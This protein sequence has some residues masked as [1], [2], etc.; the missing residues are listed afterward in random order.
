MSC[1][2]LITGCSEGG[3][4]FTLCEEFASRGCKV[5]ATARRMEAMDK[6]GHANIVKLRLDVTDDANVTDVV[7]TI[8]DRE[9]KIDVLVNNA[10]IL[11]TGAIADVPMDKVIKTFDANVFAVLRLVKA[12]F[13]HMATRKSGAIVNIGSL[14][15]DIPTPWS[16]I[17]CATKASLRSISETLWMECSPFNISVTHVSA[18][19]VR[20]N[21]STTAIKSVSLPEG[22][23]YS[24]WFDSMV[25]RTDMSQIATSMP[26]EDFARKVVTAVLSRSPP[27]YMT[28][29]DKSGLFQLF[30]W[31][32][33]RFVFWIIWTAIAG[34][35]QPKAA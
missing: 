27:R 20:S 16:G 13:P 23:F 25:K 33:K 17:Y 22:S 35:P 32:P 15:G 4:G 21:I 1:V 30:H 5:Y 8:I 2:V 28:L 31:L 34:K 11:S 10:G 24:G 18:G 19:G 7:Q 6:L 26:T 14:M 12:V 9:G 3:I 29:G